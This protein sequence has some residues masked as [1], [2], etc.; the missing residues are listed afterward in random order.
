MV[1]GAMKAGRY[2]FAYEF[3]SKHAQD[4]GTSL[5]EAEF[6]AGWIALRF[7]HKPEVALGHFQSLAKA[8]NMPI[9]VARAYYWL[10][11]TEEELKHPL[12]AIAQYSRAATNP[13]TFYNQLALA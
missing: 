13:E 9:S 12:Q 7:L 5:Y 3:A 6:M 11:R 1:R 2:D 8:V 4:S 10:G